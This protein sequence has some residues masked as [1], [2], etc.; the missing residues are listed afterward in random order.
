MPCFTQST[1]EQVL[2]GIKDLD[3]LKAALEEMGY[4]VEKTGERIDYRGINKMTGNYSTGTYAAGTLI[5]SVLE[6]VQKIQKYVAVANLKKNAA[7]HKW[8]LKKL[9]EFQYEVAK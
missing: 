7:I 5:S 1:V 9:G 8:S 4:R 6:D 2:D 3:L